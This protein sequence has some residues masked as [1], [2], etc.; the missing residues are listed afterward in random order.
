MQNSVELQGRSLKIG[1]HVLN[2]CEA[3]TAIT[4]YLLLLKSAVL[5]LLWGSKYGFSPIPTAR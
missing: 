2:Q 3:A 1:M 5:D 4:P